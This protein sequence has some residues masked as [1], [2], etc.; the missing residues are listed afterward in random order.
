M[1]SPGYIQSIT[2]PPCLAAAESYVARGWSVVPIIPGLKFPPI[3]WTP[4]R[5]RQPTDREI[6][7]WWRSWPGANIAVVTGMLSG[8]MVLDCDRKSGGPASLDALF[9]E[10]KRLPLGPVVRTARGG[11][12]FYFAA[13]PGVGS[14][15]GILNDRGLPGL[16]FR[17]DPGLA[18]LPPSRTPAGY[19]QWLVTPDEEPLPEIPAWLLEVAR[20]V[21]KA[22]PAYAGPPSPWLRPVFIALVDWLEVH[23][24]RPRQGNAGNWVAWCPLCTV[25]ERGPSLSLHAD[26]GFMCFCGCGSGGLVALARKLGIA[27]P[28]RVRWRHGH[29]ILPTIEVGP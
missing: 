6:R 24:Y 3:A 8:V 25:P 7:F 10:G 21:S 23:G 13:R 14:R 26:R 15:A 20:P 1:P 5:T 22:R 11:S 9:A 29:P 19:Y 12:H 27:V 4:Y 16:D 2:D 17:G 28:G 18:V